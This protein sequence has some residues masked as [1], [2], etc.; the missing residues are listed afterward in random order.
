MYANE[1]MTPNTVTCKPDSD[2]EGIAR[3]MWEWDCGAIVVVDNDN[4]AIGIVTDRDIAMAAMLNH[5]PLWEI[6]AS[7]IIEHQTLCRAF[8]NTSLDDCLALMK[9]QEIRRLPVVNEDGVLAG[10]LSMGDAI[11][12]TSKKLGL[13]KTS[14]T[15]S[16]DQ[17]IEMLKQVSA[18][19]EVAN[20]PVSVV[21]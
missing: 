3:M 15:V 12:F 10:I 20:H 13:S 9:E 19:H 2:L 16:Y 5:K 7:T 6:H 21:S 11:A 4:K 14:K 8:Q 1:A 17:V 18:H